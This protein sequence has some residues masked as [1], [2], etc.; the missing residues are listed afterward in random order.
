[1]SLSKMALMV[2]LIAGISASTCTI[3]N[4]TSVGVTTIQQINNTAS[5]GD[6]CQECFSYGDG[7]SCVTFEFHAGGECYLKNLPLE[8]LR[9]S[10]LSRV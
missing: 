4:D 1:M 2:N 8:R 7:Y 3:F 6:C 9:K 10:V 5:A